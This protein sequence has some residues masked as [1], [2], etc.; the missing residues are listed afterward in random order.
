[1]KNKVVII[2]GSSCSGKYTVI[3]KLLSKY[4][5][6]KFLPS[7]TTRTMRD[8]ESDGNPHIFIT[9]EEL[10]ARSISG[11][12]VV[13]EL[14]NDIYYATTFDV[15]ENA[16]ENSPIS[17][18]EIGVDGA[19]ELKKKLGDR[20]ITIFLSVEK[21]ELERRFTTRGT[22]D[23]EKRLSRYQYEFNLGNKMDV[24]I[25][26]NSDIELTIRTIEGILKLNELG[27]N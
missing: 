12:Y 19:M 21:A 24:V 20:C 14:I 18:K 17:L 4:P 1:M 23:F 26:N 9:T 13:E 7:E 25:D 22:P 10:H 16:I 11:K 15:I 2:T 6:F 5:T 27:G 8:G 3:S